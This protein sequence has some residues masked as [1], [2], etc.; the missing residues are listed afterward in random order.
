LT[1]LDSHQA[2]MPSANGSGAVKRAAAKGKTPSPPIRRGRL[3]ALARELGAALHQWVFADIGRREQAGSFY[4]NRLTASEYLANYEWVVLD[5]LL[6][7]FPPNETRV[8]EIGAGYGLLSLVLAASGYKVIAFEGLRPRFEG[9]EFLVEHFASTYPA[10]AENLLP[11]RGWF[12][13]ALSGAVTA[14]DRRNVLVATNIV[15]TAAAA[16]QD[17]I[18]RAAVAFDEVILDTTRFGITRYEL[19]LSNALRREI[20]RAMR[21]VGSVWSVNANEIWHFRPYPAFEASAEFALGKAIVGSGLRPAAR[22]PGPVVQVE[23]RQVAAELAEVERAWMLEDGGKLASDELYRGKLKQGNMLEPYE[24][25]IAH[26]ISERFQTTS[27][28][29]IEIGSGHG[30]LAI[31]LAR[32][33]YAVHGFEGNRA[34]YVGCLWQIKNQVSRRPFIEESLAVTNGMFPA[35]FDHG[36]LAPDAGNLCVATNITSTYS[37]ENQDAILRALLAFDD[38]IVDLAR[39]GQVRDSQTERD[40]LLAGIIERYFEPIETL[41][42]NDPYEYWHLRPRQIL[43]TRPKRCACADATVP[44]ISLLDDP[45][46]VFPIV[47]AVGVL[48]SV[49]GDRSLS[50]CP[51]CHCADIRP[52]WRMPMTTLSQPISLFGGY[53]NQVPTL[54]TPATV[55]CF[56]FCGECES[57]FLNPVISS[58]KEQYRNDDHY[59]RDMQDAAMWR[60]YEEVYDSLAK[61]IPPGAAVMVDAACGLGQYLEVARR[62]ATQPWRRLIGLEL[63][64]KYVADMLRRELEAH[65]FDLD[66]DELGPLIAPDQ[67]DFISFCEGFEHVE[68][69]LDVLRKLVSVLRPGG[70]LYF[71]AQ[72]YGRG[73]EAAV[74]PGEPI[75]IGEKLVRELPQRLDCSVVSVTTSS[76][77]YYI[78]LEK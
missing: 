70:R 44:A 3:P 42:F 4:Q 18:L 33:G 68:R 57:L 72:R 63:A 66:A 43:T 19:G 76:M 35:G 71:T 11:V 29:I 24:I 23:P 62:R 9:I 49:Y 55:Y 7:R 8:A 39:F 16:R 65:V 51:V 10:L 36:L 73:V 69:P 59:I 75:Y 58:Q 77:R 30:G 34:R 2:A 50:V 17:Q 64:E 60:Q 15:N 20:C 13:D 53:F 78:V 32:R 38:V 56:D 28:R 61:W 26:A 41:Y 12:P 25:A 22:L 67:A 37:A 45:N 74:R 47:G 5:Y 1:E 14:P 27:T 48:Y 52:L 21:E 46:S 40:R 54:A 31:L 6:C